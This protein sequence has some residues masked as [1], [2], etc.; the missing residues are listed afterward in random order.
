[1]STQAPALLLF[2][3]LGFLSAARRQTDLLGGLDE[4]GVRAWAT[5]DASVKGLR[6]F[7][8]L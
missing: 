5:P 6:S 3:S 7:S 1:M 2:Y 8:S 4:S